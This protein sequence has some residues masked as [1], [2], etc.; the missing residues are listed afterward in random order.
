V[1]DCLEIAESFASK[2]L[3]SKLS[4]HAD[5]NESGIPGVSLF[6]VRSLAP[7]PQR[8]E[9]KSKGSSPRASICAASL[10]TG[11][12][13]TLARL[14]KIPGFFEKS[15]NEFQHAIDV[16]AAASTSRLSASMAP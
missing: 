6:D 7:A 13:K 12:N 2:L 14:P 1:N 15:I 5:L 10:G 11:L 8:G 3:I 4:V 16:I 9:P